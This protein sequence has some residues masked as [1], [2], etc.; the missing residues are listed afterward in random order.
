MEYMLG[1]YAAYACNIIA[2]LETECPVCI[3]HPN[4]R[5]TTVGDCNY[6]SRLISN[7][8]PSGFLESLGFMFFFSF[9]HVTVIN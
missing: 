2:K 8:F 1:V 5:G 6:A 9:Y 3:R 7:M 4:F